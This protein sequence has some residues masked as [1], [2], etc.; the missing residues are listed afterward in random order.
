MRGLHGGDGELVFSAT[1][2]LA[3]AANPS[4]AFH[5]VAAET[6]L[7]SFTWEDDNGFVQTET[8]RLSVS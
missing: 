4:L 2:H 7:L 6:G 3:I 5:V 1:L 8:A